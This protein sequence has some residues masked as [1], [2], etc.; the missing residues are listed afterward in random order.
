MQTEITKLQSDNQKLSQECLNL[1][2]KNYSLN[3]QYENSKSEL[4]MMKSE[5]D[6]LM[7]KLM[8]QYNFQQEVTKIQAEY[9]LM[10][11]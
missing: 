1:K 9:N 6:N 10:I 2:G 7:S 8:S 5:K 4:E 11:E 3:T